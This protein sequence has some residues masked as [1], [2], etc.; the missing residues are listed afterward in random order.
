MSDYNINKN[1][2]LINLMI[3]NEKKANEKYFENNPDSLIILFERELKELGY[4]FEVTS[5]ILGFMPQHKKVI[6]PIAIKYYQMAK[7]FSKDN[8]QKHFLGYFHFKGIEE[9]VPMLI[10]DFCSVE[11]NDSVKWSIADCLYQIHSKKYVENYLD[12]ISS[13]Q[14]GKNRQMVILLVGKLKIEDSIPIL[15]ELLEDEEV[16]LHAICALGEFRR[17]EFRV[18]FERFAND[19]H[20]GWRKYAKAALKKISS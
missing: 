20:P 10:D 13:S 5:Q 3:E 1:T 7:N 14:Y 12:I 6:V 8:E 18:Y 2:N 11:V 15:I 19:K 16:R 9:V 17:E 4:E